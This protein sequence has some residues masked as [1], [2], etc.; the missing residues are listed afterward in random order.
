MPRHDNKE[1]KRFQEVPRPMYQAVTLVSKVTH[2]FENH[3]RSNNYPTCSYEC[4]LLV[5]MSKHNLFS[6]LESNNCQL[7]RA[8][9]ITVL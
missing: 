2:S 8:E 7:K 9:N 5:Y 6:M 4:T 1:V 3:I